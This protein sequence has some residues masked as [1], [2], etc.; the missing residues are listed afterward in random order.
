MP[1]KILSVL[2]LSLRKQGFWCLAQSIH[3]IWFSS[4]I[5]LPC[6]HQSLQNQFLPLLFFSSPWRVCGMHLH[7][8]IY[9]FSLDLTSFLERPPMELRVFLLQVLD[10]A[11]LPVV[12]RGSQIRNDSF[13]KDQKKLISSPRV[14]QINQ[15]VRFLQ[16]FTQD[17]KLL[18]PSLT[19]EFNHYVPIKVS[20]LL[21]VIVSFVSRRPLFLLMWPYRLRSLKTP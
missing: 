16:P 1:V 9:S 2:H 18:K 7:S 19:R 4:F 14:R 8:G 15:M 13:K 17:M 5:F 12:S 21:N 3:F 10:Q 11:S 20:F 6:Y